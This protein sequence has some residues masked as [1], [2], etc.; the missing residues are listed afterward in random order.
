MEN[1]CHHRQLLGSSLLNIRLQLLRL[2][3]CTHREAVRDFNQVTCPSRW[4]TVN[5]FI[6]ELFGLSDI[7]KKKLFLSKEDVRNF[8][9]H[10]I[11]GLYW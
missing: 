11:K 10:T 7:R 6:Q 3:A 9:Y 2:E 8:T 5:F 1:V 4:W